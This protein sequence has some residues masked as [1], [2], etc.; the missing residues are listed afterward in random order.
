MSLELK[1]DIWE[2]NHSYQEVGEGVSIMATVKI[3][4]YYYLE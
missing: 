4:E 1:E 3:F 2:L